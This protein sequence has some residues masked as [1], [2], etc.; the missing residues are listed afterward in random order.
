MPA[1]S[2]SALRNKTQFPKQSNVIGTI[3]YAHIDGETEWSNPKSTSKAHHHTYHRPAPVA[4]CSAFL[5]GGSIQNL[6]RHAWFLP[7]LK[8]TTPAIH[9]SLTPHQCVPLPS[10]HTNMLLPLPCYKNQQT[11]PF[12]PTCLF[13][14][15]PISLFFTAKFLDVVSLH[16]R[17]HPLKYSETHSNLAFSVTHWN[18][19]W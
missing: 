16:F 6:S 17:V 1:A 3:S 14:H 2:L 10:D 8:D 9:R 5:S 19:F 15:R 11:K 4:T 13:S 12:I 18:R 7:V